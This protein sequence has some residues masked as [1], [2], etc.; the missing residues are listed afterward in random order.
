VP[1]III[2]PRIPKSIVDHRIYDH[3]SILATIE[4]IFELD[5]LTNRDRAA[6]AVTPLLT[7]TAPRADCPKIVGPRFGIEPMTRT[8]V[9][10]PP[11][12][13]ASI[14]DTD[15]VPLLATLVAQDLQVSPP[16]EHAAIFQRAREV[17]TH[18]DAWTYMKE[19]DQKIAARCGPLTANKE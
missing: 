15:A 5:P 19:V 12:P 7:L 1:A 2:S 8:T 6:N 18:A 11:H 10:M 9:A 17:K 14:N 4:R 13:D 3:A 16:E